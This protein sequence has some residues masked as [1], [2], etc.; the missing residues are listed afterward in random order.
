MTILMFLGVT[1]SARAADFDVLQCGPG[2]GG[3]GEVT[4]EGEEFDFDPRVTIRNRGE[5][6]VDDDFTA[7]FFHQ[8]P[9]ERLSRNLAGIDLSA[10]EFPEAFECLADRT[11]G[12]EDLFLM[13]DEGT[14][15]G[16]GGCGH[17]GWI[18]AWL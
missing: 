2:R 3:G 6:F 15:N 17:G 11:L 9:M 1:G 7:E 14:D 18:R 13:P 5:G 4:D 12:D 10:G 16:D 8:F